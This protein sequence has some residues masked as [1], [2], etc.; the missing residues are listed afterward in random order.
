MAPG[1]GGIL[2]EAS[3]SVIAFSRFPLDLKAYSAVEG[4]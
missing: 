2:Y 3:G 4:I 1:N